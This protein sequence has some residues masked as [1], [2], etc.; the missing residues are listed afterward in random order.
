L[1][2]LSANGD[3]LLFGC[4]PARYQGFCREGQF[5]EFSKILVII[6]ATHVAP[7]FID[8]FHDQ[9]EV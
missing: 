8:L 3:L 4:I 6:L 1:A 7:P 9:P 2:V 5:D